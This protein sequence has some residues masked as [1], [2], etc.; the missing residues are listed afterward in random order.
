MTEIDSHSLTWTSLL[1]KWVE[2]AQASVA[3]PADADGERWRA[4]VPSIINL[5]AVTFALAELGDVPAAERPYA[6][7]MAEVLI[8]D[9]AGELDRVWGGT[10]MP[11]TILELAGDARAALEASAWAGAEELVWTGPGTM[12][13]PDLGPTLDAGTLMVMAPG[14]VVMPG[15]PVAWWADRAPLELDGCERRRPD[16]PRQVYRQVDDE[17]RF[18]RDLVVPLDDDELPAGLPLLVPLLDRGRPVGH[19]T[20]EPDRW[21]ARQETALAGRAIPVVETG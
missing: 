17:G 21:R 5:Q 20:M 6:R 11:P 12:V 16:A 1:G 18:T 19:F 7:D 15:E 2:F 4:S 3:L 13:M 10:P 8:R 14:T 9:Q